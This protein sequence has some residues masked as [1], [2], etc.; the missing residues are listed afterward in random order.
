MSAPDTTG[1]RAAQVREEPRCPDCGSLDP[2]PHDESPDA[3]FTVI[4]VLAVI[5]AVTVL[6]VVGAAIVAARQCCTPAEAQRACV[7][8]FQAVVVARKARC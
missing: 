4:L 3:L 5:G 2:C 8:A 6:G 7:D 1:P